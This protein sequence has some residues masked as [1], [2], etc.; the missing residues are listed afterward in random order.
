MATVTN[1][2]LVSALY[3]AVFNRA[4]DQAGLNAWTA[5]IDSGASSFAQ[6]AVGFAGH[7]VFTTGIG[8]LG[9]AAYVAALY[10]NILG[11]AGDTAGIANW[12]AQLNAGQSKA[13]IAAQFVQAAL[14]VNI[15]ALLA[16]GSLSA[17]D[18][19][20]ATIRQDTFTNKANVGIYFA[21]T[22][23]SA[24][25]LSATTV[26][27]SKAGLEADPIYNASKAAIANVNN[28]AASVTTAENTILAAAGTTNP[29][30]FFLGSTFTLTA[31]TDN[32]TT[33]A[34]YATSDNLI[35]ISGV[36]DTSDFHLL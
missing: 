19:A 8:A 3:A 15:P 11:S 32:S 35:T 22:L 16:A 18:A 27:S 6:V 10:T 9:N 17:A 30:A 25:N 5:T 13:A 23:K 14:T 24:S 34:D 20:A 4:P 7:E 2:Q 12:T 21:D 31:A 1:K 33:T 29:A 28:T 26:S 36:L